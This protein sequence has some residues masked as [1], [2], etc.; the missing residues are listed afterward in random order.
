MTSTPAVDWGLWIA[1]HPLLFKTAAAGSILAELLLFL[2]L[3]SRRLRR[4]LPWALLAMQVGIGLLMRVW[5]TP[6]MYV[7]LFWV[8][9]DKVFGKLTAGRVGQADELRRAPAG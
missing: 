3:F 5:F 2:A 9:W 8:P 4:V 6:Y 7:Y 1:K